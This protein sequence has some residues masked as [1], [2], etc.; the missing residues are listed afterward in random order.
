[1]PRSAVADTLPGWEAPVF[2]GMAETPM[3]HGVPLIFFVC[4]LLGTLFVAFLFVL[5]IPI[6]AVLVVL[7]GVGLYGLVRVGT[8][9]E[10]RWGRILC[11]YVTYRTRYEG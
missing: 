8:H 5:I 7:A 4:N 6:Y 10:P 3:F 9:L 11:E 1:M 2:H